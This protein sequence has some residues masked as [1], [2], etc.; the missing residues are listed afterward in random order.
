MMNKILKAIAEAFQKFILGIVFMTLLVVAALT[1]TIWLVVEMSST[2]SPFL[3]RNVSLLKIF[4]GVLLFLVITLSFYIKY[5]F[6]LK[7][8]AFNLRLSDEQRLLQKKK[9]Y[10]SSILEILKLD[11]DNDLKKLLEKGDIDSANSEI[12]GK[13]KALTQLIETVNGNNTKSLRGTDISSISEFYESTNTRIR[14][15]IAR[16][17]SSAK[18]MLSIGILAIMVVITVL[19]TTIFNFSTYKF[20][21][22]NAL[23]LLQIAPRITFSVLIGSFAFFFFNQ[24][25]KGQNEIKYWNNEKTNLDLKI[26]ALSIAIDDKKVGTTDFMRN[27]INDLIKTERNIFGTSSNLKEEQPKEDKN[28]GNDL[29]DKVKDL[30]EKVKDLTSA[31]NTKKD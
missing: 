30:T 10:L 16:Q 28:I 14:T 11:V 5:T 29:I 4:I 6:E 25:H 1:G 8:N 3:V 2:I 9:Q 13:I 23:T 24:F 21:P 27:L 15:E 26:F 17:G 22:E 12:E 31:F 19:V 7:K 18:V 20:I